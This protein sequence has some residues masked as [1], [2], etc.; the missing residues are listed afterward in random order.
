MTRP[1]ARPGRKL[2]RITDAVAWITLLLVVA[3]VLVLLFPRAPTRA[4]DAG[5]FLSPKIALRA[6][7]L[8]VTTVATEDARP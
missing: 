5:L 6:N 7:R 8:H 2:D 3:A 4:C 1:A